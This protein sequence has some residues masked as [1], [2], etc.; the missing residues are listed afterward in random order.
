MIRLFLKSFLLNSLLSLPRPYKKIIMF[1]V[2][3]F[4]I[5][6]VLWI[7]FSIRL[8]EWYQPQSDFIYWMLFTSP[9]ISTIIFNYYGLYRSVTR[10][11]SIDALWSIFQ[12]VSLYSL[13][14]G[15]LFLGGHG[16]PRSVVLINWILTILTI[17]AL[18]FFAK[19]LL[20]KGK[21]I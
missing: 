20:T 12:A 21:K 17:V 13:V 18:R 6:L 10:Y 8:G 7:S 3:S 16:W 15:A 1:F 4:S 19:W 11:V 14:W 2:D 5:V 9:V